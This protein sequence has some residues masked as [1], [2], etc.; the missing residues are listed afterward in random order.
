[1]TAYDLL[2]LPLSAYTPG[3]GDPSMEGGLQTASGAPMYTLESFLSGKAPYVT[4]ATSQKGPTG[5]LVNRTIGNQ[6][7]PVRITDYGPGVK[8]L[9]IASSN[10]KWATNFPYQGQ[11][12]HLGSALSAYDALGPDNRP[13]PLNLE[14]LGQFATRNYGGESGSDPSVLNLGNLPVSNLSASPPAQTNYS[15]LGSAISG[16][17]SGLGKSISQSSQ[18]GNQQAMAMLQKRSPGASFLQSL[19]NPGIY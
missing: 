6:T 10:S 14:N 7:V 5:E 16:I 19:L 9:D 11:T 12:D 2:N 17:F 18:Q 4:G 3:Q 13:A 8:G 15:Q 1:M